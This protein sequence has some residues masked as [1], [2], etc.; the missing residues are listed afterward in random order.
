MID[1]KDIHFGSRVRKSFAKIEEA[2]DM[3]N[4]IDIQ[5]RSY[6]WFFE[7]GLK[8]VF[9][10]MSPISDYQGNLQLY[11]L[12]YWLDKNPKY[13]IAECKERD[14]TY[15]TALR[16]RVRLVNRETGEVK[17]QDIFM[18]D[19][20]IMTDAGTF[21]INGAERVIIS[22]LIRSPGVYFTMK[23]D[24]AGKE[25]FE[26]TINPNRGAWLEYDT[27]SSGVFWVR[28]DK[29]RKLPIS[30]FIRALLKV[31]DDITMEELGSNI[32]LALTSSK[33][34]N[35]EIISIF[36]SDPYILK[37]LESK[38]AD[39]TTEDALLEVYRKLRPGEPPTIESA[40]KNLVQLLFDPHRY[41]ISRVGRYKYNKKLALANRLTGCT[42]TRPIANPTTG[43]V[44][45]EIGEL[46]SREKAE[47]LEAMGVSEAFVSVA[48]D[49][50]HKIFTNGMVDIKGFVDFDLSNEG[51]NERVCFDVLMHILET[52]SSEEEIRREVV[53]RIDDLIPRTIRKADI[54]A[55]I[56]YMC[57]LAFGIGTT[58]DI[59][60]LG[61]R[62]IRSVGEL[63]QN[64]YR[65]GFTRM[66]RIVR[67]HLS[68]Q[69]QLQD[70]E[71][72]SAQ[73][74]IN[75]RPITAAI[76]EFFGSSP[77]S[78]FMDQTNP[79]AELT[80]KRRLSALG[81]GGL[82]RDRA[83]FE[84][85]DVHYSHYGRM[86]P[87][88]TPEGPNIGLISYLATFAKINEYGFI[89][90]PYRKVDKATG[91]VTDEIVYMTADIEDEYVIAQANAPLDENNCFV[92]NKVSVR[93]RDTV[94][95][96]NREKV[97]F[98]DISPKMV[99]SVAT[100]MIPF[101]ENDDAN[102]AL[103]GANMQR[104]AVPLIR[105]E[106]PV[107]GTGM[108]YKAAVDSGTVVLA[109]EDGV[110]KYVSADKVITVDDNGEKHTYEIIKFLRSNQ[111]TCI[112]QKPLVD[113]GQRVKK[114]DVIADGPATDHGEIA[115]GKNALIGFMT[116]EGYNYEDAVLLNEK[117][118]QND[119][120]TS[121]HIEEYEIEA[122][123][124]KLGPE[125]ITRDIPSLSEDSLKDLDEYGIIRIG[126][127]VHSG[128]IL[129]GKVTP[130]GETDLTV[131]DRLLR[132]I[133]GE[134]SREVRD[135]SLRVPNGEYGTVVD[136]KVFTNENSDE[137]SPGVNKIV[138][139]Y[140][141]QKRKI[142]VGDKMAGRHGNKGVVS[143][144]LPQ[145]DMPYLPDGRPLDIVLNPLGVPSRMNIGQVLEVHLGR[146]AMA[147]GWRVM[148]PVF[149]GAHEE[150][151]RACLREAGMREDG[152]TILYDGRTGEQF[153][154]PVTVGYMYY[155]KL[156]HLVDDKIHARSTG[157]YSMIT[158]QPL[159]GK[160]Q[161][162]GQRFG[163]M[164]VWALEAYGAAYTLQEIL[165]VKSDDM[166][167]RVETF[168][169]IVKGMNVPTPGIPESFKVLIKELQSL[170][171]DVAVIDKDN[172]K[173]DLI[174]TFDDEEKH[175]GFMK[176]RTMLDTMSDDFS[177]VD[178]DELDDDIIDDELDDEL[179]DN[180]LDDEE[181]DFD[182][183][184]PDDIDDIDIDSEDFADVPDS[185][186]LSL[187][188][189]D[190][191]Q[192]ELDDDFSIEP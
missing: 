168:E 151:I 2:Q 162:G 15:S 101:L 8:Q 171:L 33:S 57:G 107:V 73:T 124:T 158:Q 76:K 88:E 36:G 133:F 34:T 11:F 67:E 99:V 19:F 78:Q 155:L 170:A 59:D 72:I 175:G 80:H 87:I 187:L 114:G 29:N 181:F 180:E 10:E 182:E 16:A 165:T 26:S 116:W 3:P 169:A 140:L 166:S 118:I 24:N 35:D 60:H 9:R 145:E 23:R 154:N 79:L 21:V 25:L 84:V 125:E 152:K 61:N 178:D 22:Q 109:K 153:D 147:L 17:E 5:K 127:E 14:T 96:V 12:D 20:P 4:L 132:A 105:T 113:V 174:N 66:E 163:E 112:N 43:E 115:L 172:N 189:I 111:G 123:D 104:Q 186:D 139:C 44:V 75:I 142:S 49:R 121:I 53:A 27:D 185:D 138:R 157:P 191:L 103:M 98:M 129:V 54:F 31:R 192:D 190:D 64:S 39:F 177:A 28:V 58:D 18:G 122:R 137:L 92:E 136:V 130:K 135:K 179:L 90:A 62:R 141:A 1:V 42:L 55:S 85:R 150:D 106:A 50:E 126:A 173:I 45:A 159:G 63:L 167:G 134:K 148:T 93:Y 74:L 160:A 128:D 164:E 184:D 47:Q 149:D 38:D 86:C 30:T 48:D 117:L 71:S 51:V 94:Q 97:D 120:Y 56:N 156:H 52:C 108:E 144:I 89:E 119:V 146:A 183:E 13:T 110:V 77:L 161:F 6:N 69:T 188:D 131:E 83:G 32:E 102:R 176:N 37:T 100:S 41:N 7:V 65:I 70:K 46:I 68:T 95:E 81:P 143:R 82:S 91:R 40:V